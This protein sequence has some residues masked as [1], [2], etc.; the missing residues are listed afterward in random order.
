MWAAWSTGWCP[1]LRRGGRGAEATP[2]RPPDHGRGRRAVLGVSG[3]A[4]PFPAREP[5]CRDALTPLRYVRDGSPLLSQ[6]GPGHGALGLDLRTDARLRP[7]LPR[8]ALRGRPD[9]GPRAVRGALA[10]RTA[11][12]SGA[13]GSAGSS[14]GSSRGSPDAAGASAAPS[15]SRTP[16][17]RLHRTTR[18]RRRPE[19]GAF[20]ALLQD[21]RK[22]FSGVPC[23]CSWSSRSTWSSR[24][25]RARRRDG[26]LDEATWY[27]VVIAIGFNVAAFGAYVALFRGV[28]GGTHRD[29]VRRRLDCAPPTRSR[30]PAWPPRASSPPPAPAGSC[31][32][33]GRCGRR[34]AAPA[35]GLPDGRLPGADLRRLHRRARDLRHPAAHRRAPRATPLRR[36]RRAG[37]RGCG[38][39]RRSSC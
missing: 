5:V 25:R 13:R 15:G 3:P 7:R 35:L 32:P 16:R 10:R 39:D 34:A 6:I 38:R 22:L 11:A 14:T 36:H 9:R 19:V 8:R 31:S 23:S 17:A 12:G 1:P 37:R 2:A 30:W 21:R 33:T 24:S 20:Q 27:W 29:D 18:R 4:L 28:L 26:A